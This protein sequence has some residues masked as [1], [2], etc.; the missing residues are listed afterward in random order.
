MCWMRLS[1]F[2]LIKKRE[3]VFEQKSLLTLHISDRHY[4]P[5]EKCVCVCVY[6]EYIPVQSAA[7][8][9]HN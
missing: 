5:T 3:T 6:V 4:L 1:S 7:E 9:L 8:L 2:D